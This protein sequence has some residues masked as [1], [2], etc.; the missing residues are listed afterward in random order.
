M[1]RPQRECS[2]VNFTMSKFGIVARCDR[3]ESSGSYGGVVS[4]YR[5]P[6]ACYHRKDSN[7]TFREPAVFP[8]PL[9]SQPLAA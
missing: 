7:R 5:Q 1:I 9:A 4:S 8:I 3:D 2:P 6:L